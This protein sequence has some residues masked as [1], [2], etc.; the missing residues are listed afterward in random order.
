MSSLQ[1]IFT[2]LLN[3]AAGQ[4]TSFVGM[5]AGSALYVQPTLKEV[6][7]SDGLQHLVSLLG[8]AIP[9]TIVVF[10]HDFRYYN[11]FKNASINFVIAASISALSSPTTGTPT[12]VSEQRQTVLGVLT[13]ASA[14]IGV[15]KTVAE[16]GTL[17][18]FYK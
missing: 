16:Y 5:A 1:S 4:Q 18:K 9:A 2:N 7:L 15:S 11:E 12:T 13:V 14:P 6:G 17:G 8:L 3:I 10:D